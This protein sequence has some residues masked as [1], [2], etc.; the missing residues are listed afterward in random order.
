MTS[1]FSPNL[2]YKCMMCP[3]RPQKILVMIHLQVALRQ[4]IQ[5]AKK[6]QVTKKF[7]TRKK[8][9]GIFHMRSSYEITL[10]NHFSPVPKTQQ[11]T[12]KQFI[13]FYFFFLFFLTWESPLTFRSRID[14]S[15]S[16]KPIFS[17]FGLQGFTRPHMKY[18]NI[19]IYIYMFFS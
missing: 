6:R 5:K 11:N 4:P 14:F 8:V 18:P 16:D 12:K 1:Q 3:R 17:T 13:F 15:Q 19:Y 2:V 9:I 7:L 10:V